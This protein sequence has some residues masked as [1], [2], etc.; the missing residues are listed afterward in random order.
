TD[1]RSALD[2]LR[3]AASSDAGSGT[4]VAMVISDFT[5]GSADLSSPLAPMLA[6][7]PNIRIVATAPITAMPGNVQITG[8]DPLRSV[9]LAGSDD[10]TSPDEQQQVRISLSRNG[11]FVQ[12][13]QVT[14]VRLRV[15]SA[16]DADDAS[17]VAAGLGST[18]TVSWRP[19]QEQAIASVQINAATIR[20]AID[21]SAG[22]SAVLIAEIDRDALEADNIFRRPVALRDALRVGIV[23]Q[24]RFG[25]GP[26]VDQLEPADWFRIALEPQIG[27]PIETIDM[28]PTALDE[29]L[30]SQLDAAI[31]S[32]PHLVTDEG[33]AVLASFVN[34]G[35]L[36]LITPPSEDMVNLWTDQL[37][38][39]FGLDWRLSREVTLRE[40]EPMQLIGD[41]ASS[42]LVSLISAELPRL[43]RNITVTRALGFEEVPEGADRILDVRD[44]QT[45]S[46]IPWLVAQRP[47]RDE[48]SSAADRGLIIFMASPPDARSTNLPLMPLMVPLTQELIRQGVGRAS[49]ATSVMAG[50]APPAPSGTA[51]LVSSGE[52]ISAAG[53]AVGPAGI[54]ERA[55]RTAGTYLAFDDVDR[56]RGVIAINTDTRGSDLTVQQPEAVEAWLAD[57]TAGAGQAPLAWVQPDQVGA[58]LQSADE[59]S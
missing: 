15:A 2:Q 5:R 20:A 14:T 10:E 27:V 22:S 35:G 30:L 19:G 40:S 29:P 13:S 18:T 59:G 57:V 36:L 54:T 12:E 1:L 37:G 6:D 23:A 42:I 31:L 11:P 51:R 21:A 39:V 26:T 4:T 41:D 24:R 49:G 58:A 25:R 28:N 9:V 47:Q 33:W 7:V 8:V 56:E 3:S 46:T 17:A 44:P 50:N 32:Q 34:A 48:M 52:S 43:A 38:S 45:G 53:I 55:I 16:R